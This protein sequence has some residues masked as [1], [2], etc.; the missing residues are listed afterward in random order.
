MFAS[1][2]GGRLTA[3]AVRGM[4]KRTAARAG[5]NA[6]MSPHWLRYAHGSHAIDEGAPLHE[7]QANPADA[8]FSRG[9]ES[10]ESHLAPGL[11][12]RL[13]RV[14]PDGEVLPTISLAGPV[15]CW[16]WLR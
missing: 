11:A 10:S 5:A 7:V 8:S 12:L 2:K 4:V 15:C 16:A 6:A 9:N 3:R 13:H 14:R 1:R